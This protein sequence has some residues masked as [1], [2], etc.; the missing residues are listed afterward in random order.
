MS[1]ERSR[2]FP[3]VPT[4]AEAGYDVQVSA[5]GG[6]M[7]PAGL[8]EDRRDRLSSALSNIIQSDGFAEF[9][10][11]RGLERAYKGAGAFTDFVRSEYDRF[12]TLADEMNLQVQ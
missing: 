11:Q 7:T 8:P 1:D 2:L 10:E 3:D 12:G 9:C 6:F 5:W 4:L